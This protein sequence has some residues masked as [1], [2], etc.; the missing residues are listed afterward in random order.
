MCIPDGFIID[1]YVRVS[2]LND[3]GKDDF[4]A[5]KYN[6]K[7]D[8]QLD[9]DSTYW[10]LYNRSKSDTTFLLQMTLS[11][12]VPPFIKDLSYEY[13]LAHPVASDLFD[14][15]PRRLSHS[16]SFQLNQ[17]TIKLSYKF[18]DT[19][20]KRFIFVYDKAN[21][22]LE[23]VEYFIGEL[24]MYWWR[25][26]DFYYPLNDELKVIESRKPKVKVSINN[27]DLKAAFKYRDIEWIHLS[28]W[29][30]DRIDKTKWSS[31]KDV[32]FSKCQGIDLPDD[33]IY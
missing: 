6:K 20:G 13:L 25:D 31:I 22:Y 19:Y 1:D 7:E 32:K 11:N 9:G 26:D 14:S 8:D 17:D 15:Y 16:H 18:E 21:W 5:L 27:F 4:I 12:I 3:D 28:N 33:W 24:P 23:N 2:D 30:I 29:H 10:R